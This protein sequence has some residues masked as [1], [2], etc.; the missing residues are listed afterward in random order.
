M[1]LVYWGFSLYRI[2]VYS[3]CSLYRI[4]VYSGI[5]LNIFHCDSFVKHNKL[6]FPRRNKIFTLEWS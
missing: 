3:G 6:A 1:I 4:L 2:L 5:G